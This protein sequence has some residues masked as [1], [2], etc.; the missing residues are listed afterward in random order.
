MENDF[1]QSP[2]PPPS[3]EATPSNAAP[4]EAAKKLV[5]FIGRIEDLEQEKT[6]IGKDIRDIYLEAKVAGYDTKILR[7]V[8]RLRKMDPEEREQMTI[9]LDHYRSLLN[10]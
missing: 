8:I 10:L 1:Q 6:A 3:P 7:E 4:D 9:L 2:P 5:A